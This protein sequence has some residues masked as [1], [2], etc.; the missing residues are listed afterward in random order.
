MIPLVVKREQLMTANGLFILG[1]QASFVLGFAVLGPLV[2]TLVGT[3]SLI[4]IVA[5]AY[6]ARRRSCAGPCPRAPPS[7]AAR[8]ETLRCARSGGAVG[9]RCRSCARASATSADHRNIF[10][11]LTYLTITSSLIGVLGVL[12]PDFAVSVLGLAEDDF[13]DRRAAAGR[14][15]SSSASSCSTSTASYVRAPAAHRDRHGRAGHRRC[16]SSALAQRRRPAS[17]TGPARCRSSRS[18]SSVAFTAGISMPSSPCPPRPRSRRS[19]RAD[20]RG[21]VFGVLNTLVSLAASCPS[22]SSGPLADVIGLIVGHRHARRSSSSARRR[23]SRSSSRTR[24]CT[25]PARP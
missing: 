1:L 19:C 21:R 3:Q 17:A 15:A 9:R 20:V 7:D 10:W 16:S 25:G 12:G 5:G 6:A 2:Q 13:V 18:S 24:P 11:S 8:R 23:R 4:I 14:R 22:S